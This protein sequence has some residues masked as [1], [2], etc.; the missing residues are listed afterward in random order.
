MTEPITLELFASDEELAELEAR[1]AVAP[2]APD[3]ALALAWAL[4]QRDPE[5]SLN[6]ARIAADADPAWQP[7]LWL[8]EGDRAAALGCLDE[9]DVW[10]ARA[11]AAFESSCDHVGQVDALFLQLIT[12]SQRGGVSDF[13]PLCAKILAVAE[14][15]GHAQRR[16]YFG[17]AL[18]R[19][20]L[21]NEGAEAV[22][23]NLSLLP[24]EGDALHPAVAAQLAVYEG[25]ICLRH[26]DHPA[27]VACFVRAHALALR[28]GQGRFASLAATSVA[29]AHDAAGDPASA[30]EWSQTALALALAAWPAFRSFSL[31][32][33]VVLLRRL[34]QLQEA[35]DLAQECLQH[36]S[37][38]PGSRAYIMALSELGAV[39]LACDQ[40]EEALR[41]FDEVLNNP[42]LWSDQRFETMIERTEAMLQLRRYAEAQASAEESLRLSGA[43]SLAAMVLR[44]RGQ[45]ADAWLA[46]GQADQAQRAYAAVLQECAALEDFQP[47]VSVLEGAARAYAAVG[48]HAEA[49]ALSQRAC[50]A[51][52][53]RHSRLAEQRSRMLYAR[54]RTER[55]QLEVEHQRRLAEA[56]AEQLA[57]LERSHSVLEQ[58]G[59][60]GRELTAQLDSGRAL[61]VLAQYVRSLLEVDS[62]MVY[63]LDASG[64]KLECALFEDEG[65]P[66]QADARELD[67]PHSLIARCAR[68]REVLLFQDEAAQG[69]G[70]RVPGTRLKRSM[71]Y[72]PLCIG[73]VLVGVM[74]IQAE[75]AEA[76]DAQAQLIFGSLCAYAAIALDNARAYQ[77]L[78]QMQRQLRAQ[79]RMAAL[80]AMVAGV[81]HE[82]HTPLGNALLAAS[83]LT[84]R[85]ADLEQR[86]GAGTLR[87][88]DMQQHAE[89]MKSGLEMI[90]GGVDAS[91]RL[92]GNFRQVA[93]RR[94]TQQRG[95]FRLAALCRQSLAMR[96]EQARQRG[97]GIEIEVPADMELD[98]YADAVDQ[99][100]DIL[101]GNALQHGLSDQQPGRVIVRAERIDAEHCRLEVIDDGCGMKPEVLARA[102]E[103]FFTTTFGKGGNGLGLSICHTIVEDVLGGTIEAFSESGGG[104]RFV[105]ELP[106]DAP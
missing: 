22:A 100:L 48:L 93:Q 35:R 17:I 23:T 12:S 59:A 49:C 34:G 79:E 88:S 73:S 13:A 33:T 9:A 3:A 32:H 43:A 82:L 80:G 44:A 52:K 70:I 29:V 6:L 92:V 36:E 31:A 10:Q 25:N 86:L 8:V 68:E 20:Y 55:S 72:A 5:W 38:R 84:E 89:A 95:R 71:I 98:S 18:A 54:F 62:Q 94:D 41:K 87:R 30:L 28:S 56:A 27:A 11:L 50:E 61:A 81:A 77:Q 96:A 58:L 19:Q 7:R 45:L 103:P 102:F 16:A 99:A 85:S 14:A 53:S 91:L 4:R 57:G 47:L 63:L 104:S 106:L 105:M 21:L 2:D 64:Q 1:Y 76:F 78:Q 75:R 69:L 101:V 74:S 39:E 42:A 90:M 15:S 51:L 83:T 26:G 65:Q 60:I 66:A 24:R 67:D 37:A 40:P 97:H 46:Q